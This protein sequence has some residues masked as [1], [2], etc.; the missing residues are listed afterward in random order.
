MTPKEKAEVLFESMACQLESEQSK[1]AIKCALVAVAHLIDESSS[2]TVTIRFS[3]CRL[4][5]KD[6]WK[7]VRTEL[8]NLL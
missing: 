7:N 3:G 5:D 1:E 6:Y 4:T 2:K 8:R